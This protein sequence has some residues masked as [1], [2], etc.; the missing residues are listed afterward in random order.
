MAKTRLLLML[1]LDAFRPDYLPRTRWLA[2]WAQK[3]LRGCL[4]E[5]FGFSPRASYFG[6]LKPAEV[7]FTHLFCYNPQESPFGVARG[8]SWVEE[9]V[10]ALADQARLWLTQL[11][12]ERVPSFAAAYLSTF[13]IPLRFLPFFAPTEKYAPW[14]PKVGYNSLFLQL[15]AQRLPWIQCSWP[16]SNQLP[17]SDDAAIV[18]NV[19]SQLR[20]DHRMAYVH[21]QQLDSLGHT[22]GPGSSEVQRGLEEIDQLVRRLVEHCQRLFDAVDVLIWGD[23]GMV[24]VVHSVDLWSLLDKSGLRFG[25]DFVYFLDS[26]MAR[27]WFH[28]NFAKR[29]VIELLTPLR[30][31]IILQ[32]EHLQKFHIAGCDWR[33][34]ELI[35]LLHPGIVIYPNFFQRTG[36]PVRGMHGYD[37]DC[38][39]NMGLFLLYTDDIQPGEIPPI[40]AW[41][42]Y[43][44]ALELLQLPGPRKLSALHMPRLSPKGRYTQALLPKAD[45]VIEQHLQS[46]AT[47]IK[48]VCPDMTALLLV[49]GFGRGEGGVYQD[50]AGQIRP[51]NDFDLIAL[52]TQIPQSNLKTIR[53]KLAKQIGIDYVDI[54]AQKAPWPEV[55]PPLFYFD[56]SYGSQLLVGPPEVLA[57]LPKYAPAQIPLSEGVRL[58]LN[59]AAG[60]MIGLEGFSIQKR[61]EE[62]QRKFLSNQIIKALI[63]IGDW[64]LL[65]WADYHTLYAIRRERFSLLASAYGLSTA[66]IEHVKQAY[67]LKITPDYGKIKD[68]H[69]WLYQTI[70]W[71]LETLVHAVGVLTHTQPSDLVEA[72]TIYHDTQRSKEDNL[73][74]LRKRAGKHWAQ[75]LE[76][77]VEG[78]LGI[79]P[80]LYAAIALLLMALK[81]TEVDSFYLRE[82]SRWLSRLITLP[83]WQLDSKGWEVCREQAVALWEELCH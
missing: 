29:K 52:G 82:G 55:S 69:E 53:Q 12:R 24:T 79:R 59:R 76:V 54:V 45:T 48:K 68:L 39:D 71:L 11:G 78:V 74:C 27:F 28:T 22:Y 21:L 10:P 36:Q 18:D 5:P 80:A 62:P 35:F 25:H 73:D 3:S 61:L 9:K 20:P 43:F 33:N 2:R 56:C 8:L 77:F 15:D 57:W 75:S 6:G 44:T 65:E 66:L 63:A 46:I 67:S 50:E 31:G 7:G 81:P 13:E 40:D 4:R 30:E 37:P 41:Q 47:E 51:I 14:D 32:Q 38:S 64:Y 16:L 19:I 58:L 70:A 49:G 26:T 42:I 34:G 83:E 17:R 1:L 23:H 60:L 72:M